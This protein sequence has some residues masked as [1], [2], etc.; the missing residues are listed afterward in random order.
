MEALGVRSSQEMK[1]H[2]IRLE[3]IRAALNA[4]FAE[5]M[6][7]RERGDHLCLT[8]QRNGWEQQNQNDAP[9]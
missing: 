1:V 6:F 4:D 5:M 3:E 2:E 7:A 9:Q 8:E